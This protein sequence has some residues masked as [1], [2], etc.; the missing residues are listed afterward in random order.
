MRDSEMTTKTTRR[1]VFGALAAFAA[2]PAAVAVAA[3]PD[4][5]FPALEAHKA[6][7]AAWE[8]ALTA[9]K[10]ATFRTSPSGRSHRRSKQLEQQ[11]K[12][13]W[14]LEEEANEEHKSA[15]M[16]LL[17]TMPTTM[18]GLT[19]ALEYMGNDYDGF[20]CSWLGAMERWGR[21]TEIEAAARTYLSRLGEAL[22]GMA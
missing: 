1:T 19:A 3:M 2:A 22:R 16:E 8:V 20:G 17:S 9:W 7:S 12:H 13:L 4:P 6:A 14:R 5:L 15:T 11:I 10:D 18:R 21:N